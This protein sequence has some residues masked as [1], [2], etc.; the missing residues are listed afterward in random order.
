MTKIISVIIASLRLDEDLSKTIYSCQNQTGVKLE[1]IICIKSLADSSPRIETNTQSTFPITL[2]YYNDTG[3]ADAWNLCLQHARGDYFNFLGAGDTYLDAASLEH[4]L[5]PYQS[6]AYQNQLLVTYGKQLINTFPRRHSH[7]YVPG[8]EH[9]FLRRFMIIPHASSLW[10]KALFDYCM[11]S[12][13]YPIAVDY[14]FVLR[15]HNIVSFHHV[16]YLVACVLPGGVSNKPEKL[17]SVIAQDFSIK[18][19]LGHNPFTGLMLN[20]K[21]FLRWIIKI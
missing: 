19:S 1:L 4:L 9:I 2:I 3:I 20:F 6:P 12:T 5:L 11:F 7:F 16:D 14:H 17:L 18:R 10:P 8:R 15:I 13:E 21:R